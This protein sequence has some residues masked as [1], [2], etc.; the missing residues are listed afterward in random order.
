MYQ[1]MSKDSPGYI[2]PCCFLTFSLIFI[3]LII[4]D[5]N[6]FF[7]NSESN[8]YKIASVGITKV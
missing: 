6:V 7:K 4:M 8:S 1:T 3:L 5:T 2:N